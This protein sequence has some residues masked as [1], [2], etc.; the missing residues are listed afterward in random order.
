MSAERINAELENIIRINK[1]S[2][3]KTKKIVI[4]GCV[5]IIS[6]VNVI[7]AIKMTSPVTELF[8]LEN[9]E[10][11]ASTRASYEN[12]RN[13]Y[14]TNPKGAVGCV[15]DIQHRECTFSIFCIK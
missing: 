5:L 14:C 15:D 6:I 4:I 10:S 1:R 8:S 13:Q 2:I 12:A 11:S 9:V 3:M 7:T